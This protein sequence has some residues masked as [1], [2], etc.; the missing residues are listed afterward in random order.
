MTNDIMKIAEKLAH[1]DA[2]NELKKYLQCVVV[3]SVV[4]VDGATTISLAHNNGKRE[5]AL[6]IINAMGTAIKNK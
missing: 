6:L 5:M 4:A 1:T 3:G 2:G